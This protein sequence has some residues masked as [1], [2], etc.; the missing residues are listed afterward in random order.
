VI[1]MTA[2]LA[3][4][5]T[6]EKEQAKR[7]QIAREDALVEQADLEAYRKFGFDPDNP[8]DAE[9]IRMIIRVRKHM[10]TYDVFGHKLLETG[11][12]PASIFRLTTGMDDDR[13]PTD[14]EIVSCSTVEY[15]D[16]HY[17]ITWQLDCGTDYVVHWATADDNGGFWEVKT[18]MRDEPYEIQTG[19][20]YDDMDCVYSTIVGS[21]MCQN[22]MFKWQQNK[23]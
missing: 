14:D 13:H 7:E 17:T 12:F 21:Y 18:P 23:E 2:F 22:K 3:R 4:K 16:T 10:T 15:V 1:E 19:N 11:I 8:A 6:P 5:L 20:V 9:M